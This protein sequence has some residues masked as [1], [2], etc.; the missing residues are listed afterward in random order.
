MRFRFSRARGPARRAPRLARFDRPRRSAP[1]NIPKALGD[2]TAPA[3]PARVPPA[4]L[5]IR[6][7]R[8]HRGV[9]TR[10]KR[11]TAGAGRPGVEQASGPRAA[12]PAAR[13]ARALPPRDHSVL[14]VRLGSSPLRQS[15][16]RARTGDPP[17][18]SQSVSLASFLRVGHLAHLWCQGI[19]GGAV[20]ALSFKSTAGRL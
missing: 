12:L 6:K 7:R 18:T 14:T 3:A 9:R 5:A 10:R 20:L 2:C 16:R 19:S 17:S 4:V 1:R 13:F 11:G 8:V 15:S